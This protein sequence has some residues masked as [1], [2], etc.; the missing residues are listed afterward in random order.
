[1]SAVVFDAMGTLFDLEPLRERLGAPAL[2][3]WFERVQHSAATLTLTGAF[4]P[5]DEVA[6]AA[7]RTTAAR[8]GLTV[9]PDEALELLSRLPPA[10]DAAEAIAAARAAGAEVAVLTNGT[11]ENTRRLLELGALPVE[12]VF[13]TEQVGAYK[14]APAPY[15][16][17]AERLGLE[18]RQ[19][20]LV[21]A[22]GWDV[23]GALNAGLQA[24]WV[25]RDER[26]W[27]FPLPE[28]RGAPS[29]P[30]AV[31]LALEGDA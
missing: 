6:S 4:R 24:V 18:P 1:M 28:P 12:H 30:E 3:A 7:F 8:L 15:L 5:F 31:A 22:H 26:E 2:E 21:A 25:D 10:Q 20:T 29:L 17:A 14:P 9:E 23:L 16:D 19:V 11:E 13:A 27:P